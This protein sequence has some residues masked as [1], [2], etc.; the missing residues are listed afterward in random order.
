MSP[1]SLRLRPQTAVDI[2]SLADAIS[3]VVPDDGPRFIDA[4][5][6]ACRRLADTPD[7]GGDRHRHIVP[8]LP[9]ALRALPVPGFPHILLFYMPLPDAVE[10]IR[11]IDTARGMEP[12]AEDIAA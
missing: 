9:V 12:L 10:L 1:R 7:I 2:A 4:V 8:E 3:G 5:D 11:V 6:V